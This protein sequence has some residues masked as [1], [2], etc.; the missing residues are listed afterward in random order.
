MPVSEE[1]VADIGG[2]KIVAG[3]RS[4]RADRIAKRPL[5]GTSA[6][7]GSVKGAEGAV[8][9]AQETMADICRIDII[10]RDRSVR[11]DDERTKRKR[12]LER[13]RSRSWGVENGD[14]APFCPNIPV[15]GIRRI[16]E[17]A[18]NGSARVDGIGPRPLPGRGARTRRT[19]ERK[20]TLIR[21]DEAMAD[22][23]GVAAI[24]NHRPGRSDIETVSA[25]ENTG[26]RP[27]GI[28]GGDRLPRGGKG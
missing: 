9:I 1:A 23:V 20:R 5:A 3:D 22:V 14:R 17:K 6:G 24:A 28:K 8:P 13:A 4:I 12:P 10:T 2:V 27:R 25:L 21:P 15:H 11:S 26:A 18:S 16:E 7:A 19:E